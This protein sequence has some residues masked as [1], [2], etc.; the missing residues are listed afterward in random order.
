MSGPGDAEPTPSAD[1][2]Q[3][4]SALGV[5]ADGLTA[6]GV[7]RLAAH[8]GVRHV[9]AAD[10]TAA[11]ERA[12]SD[13]WFDPSGVPTA[14]ARTVIRR[15]LTD[16][17]RLTI[18]AEVARALLALGLERV[19][20]ALVHARAA[21]GGPDGGDLVPALDRVGRMAL[22]LADYRT[23]DELFVLAAEIDEAPRSARAAARSCD[24]AEAAEGLG[25]AARARRLL[26]QAFAVAAASAA[27]DVMARASVALALLDD[28]VVADGRGPALLRQV[29][30][31]DL[32][33]DDR[34][35]VEATQAFVERRLPSVVV[36]GRPV[37]WVERPSVG[38]ALADAALARS[39]TVGIESRALA[40]RAWRATHTAPA[41]LHRRREVSSELLDLTQQCHKP[42]QHY[43]AAEWVAVDALEA[44]DR[45]AYDRAIDLARWVALHD[46]NPRLVRRSLLLSGGAAL[47][48][49][50]D[51]RA[52]HLVER[53]RELDDGVDPVADLAFAA[54]RWLAGL[55]TA[56]RCERLVTDDRCEITSEPLHRVVLASLR[57][58]S[59]DHLEA[60]Q[61]LRRTVRQ[62]E[63][64]HDLLLI[65][66]LA[67]GVAASIGAVDLSRD[68]VG[69]LAPWSGLVAV[70]GR[71][72]WCD[73]PVALRL[74]R[75]HHLL[76]D[77]DAAWRCLE[78]GEALARS[79]NDVLAVQRAGDLRAVL[80]RHGPA[81]EPVRLTARELQV[82]TL[83]AAGST[84]PQIAVQ[85]A[86]SVATV[87]ADTISIYRKLG[88][89]GRAE[90][91]ARAQA[92]GLIGISAPSGRDLAGRTPR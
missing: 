53:A 38:R 64:E 58:A 78:Q 10:V 76:G 15:I 11:L 20:E 55:D 54:Q 49:G 63:P 30:S 28:G 35:A 4:L 77:L 19:P 57:A 62:L 84:N 21:A 32:G 71:G 45:A 51:E 8:L 68:L 14:Q 70:D 13:G 34:I 44:G 59:G 27:P 40:L 60:E 91:S 80:Q 86:H 39:A 23:A 37:A 12:R 3:L 1:R 42:G 16:E 33:A 83:L 52:A 61:Q 74:G 2:W 65:G 50:D 31:L 89:K 17:Q 18:E 66:G 25:D 82:L 81:P 6:N 43:D 29:V 24:G 75:L 9:T 5:I 48:D 79:V 22:E 88:A 36:D 41:Y 85:L 67:A 26:V 90:A 72:W 7:A 47:L 73:G 56:Q 87:R 92:L 69:V 46:G